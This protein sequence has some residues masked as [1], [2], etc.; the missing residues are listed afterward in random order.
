MNTYSSDKKVC[1]DGLGTITSSLIPGDIYSV[2]QA[3]ASKEVQKILLDQDISFNKSTLNQLVDM[4][5]YAPENNGVIMVP[6]TFTL[7]RE[8]LNRF[9]AALRASG[10]YITT[11]MQNHQNKDMANVVTSVSN[12]ELSFLKNLSEFKVKE[13]SVSSYYGERTPPPLFAL[14]KFLSPKTD[15]KT[16]DR[17]NQLANGKIE[18]NKLV[19]AVDLKSTF[20]KDFITLA[21]AVHLPTSDFVKEVNGKQVEIF[22]TKENY[23]NVLYRV[24]TSPTITLFRISEK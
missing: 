23:Y 3:L 16:K 15:R 9:H 22:L 8:S 14:L 13:I 7:P 11:P 2:K 21:L 10:I 4:F 19:L 20:Y 6:L 12:S 24:L 17:I 5:M 18:G 1:V